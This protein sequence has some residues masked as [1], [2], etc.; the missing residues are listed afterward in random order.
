MYE[1]RFHFALKD[2]VPVNAVGALD[3]AFKTGVTARSRSPPGS[4]PVRI[5]K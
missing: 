4:P 1:C 3:Y 5:V 2:N